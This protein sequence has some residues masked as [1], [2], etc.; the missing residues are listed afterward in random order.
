MAKKS[1]VLFEDDKRQ[2]AEITAAFKKTFRNDVTVFPFEAGKNLKKPAAANQ[3]YESRL[4]N[5]LA[6]AGLGEIILFVTDRDLSKTPGYAGF[7]EA[8]VSQVSEELSVPMCVYSQA[9]KADALRRARSWSDFKIILDI[10]KGADLLARECRIISAGFE[11]IG[12]A[13]KKLS[14]SSKASQQTP[15]EILATVLGEPG[16]KDR[17]A[18]YGAGDQHMLAEIFPYYNQA[19]PKKKRLEELQR[20]MKRS[21]GYWLWDSII[22]FPGLLVNTGAAASYLGIS[23]ATFDEKTQTL[24]KSAVYSGPFSGIYPL[25]WRHKLDG[26]L[27]TAGA[28]SGFDYAKKN[29]LKVSPCKCFVDQRVGAGYYCMV[30]RKPICAKH[31]RSNISWFPSG[32]DLARISKSTFDELAPWLGL[33]S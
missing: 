19:L 11:E 7:S 28:K 26:I 21:L 4:K 13:C 1:I 33:Y 8:V 30:E 3:T 15:A 6:A 27:M 25:W 24:F 17:I 32:A 20:R 12:A 29:R 10:S 16:V 2:L 14:A 9:Q 23:E 31:S 22:R 5:D 18:L